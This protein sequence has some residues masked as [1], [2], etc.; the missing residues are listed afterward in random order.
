LLFGEALVISNEELKRDF[1][2]ILKQNGG[3]LAKGF[4]L[5]IQFCALF[6]DGLYLRLSEQANAKADM[7]RRGL[8]ELGYGFEI[9]SVTN[10]VF[11]VVT[12]AA[13]AELDKRVLFERWRQ[14]DGGLA[15]IRFTT[16]WATPDSDI[17]A[18]LSIMSGLPGPHMTQ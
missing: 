10:Q 16:T 15:S 6:R 1:R 8:R 12:D 2:F 11:P 18:L 13:V 4:V 9:D 17:E 14:L 7:L 5:G 3:M